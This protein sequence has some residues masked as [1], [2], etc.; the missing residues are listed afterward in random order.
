MR[1][2]RRIDFVIVNAENATNGAGLRPKEAEE[3]FL[4]GADC[5]TTGDHILDHDEIRGYLD[6][7]PRLLRPC[8]YDMPGRGTGLYRLSEGVVVGVVNVA[9]H[10][11]MKDVG[12]VGNAFHAASRA[13]EAVRAETPIVLVDVHAE[14]TSEKLAMGWHLDGQASAVFGSHTH[15]QTADAQILPKGTGYLTDLGMTGPHFGVLGRDKDAVLL[16]FVEERH[17]FFKVARDWPRM[18]GAIFTIDADSGCCTEVELFRHAPEE[19]I[20]VPDQELP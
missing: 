13:V 8:N 11:F 4:A 9:G 2:D 18:T 7:E 20:P 14:A 1:A 10:V 19:G 16:R 17:A 6:V 5:L 3:L 12:P 15:V